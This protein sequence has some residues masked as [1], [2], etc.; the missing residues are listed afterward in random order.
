M[1]KFPRNALFAGIA[2]GA[3]FVAGVISLIG[4]VADDSPSAVAAAL[5]SGRMWALIALFGVGLATMLGLW[6]MSA[7][8]GWLR[9]AVPAGGE[10]LGTVALVASTLA[11]GLALTG[12]AL[13][14][15]ATYRLAGH[16]GSA[17]LLGLA[18]AANA[19][20]MMTKFAGAMVVVEISIAMSRTDHT[21]GW[22]AKLGYFSV[23]ALIASSVG[24]FTTDTFTQFGGPLDFYGTLPAAAWSLVLLALLYRTGL[25]DPTPAR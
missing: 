19:A 25:P 21:P 3:L 5:Q 14:Y 7:L 22:F 9:L 10:E 18:D 12:M 2:G 4:P 17:A 8:R 23:F 20:M 11:T 1:P 24:I 6:F 16:G 15:G 13:F